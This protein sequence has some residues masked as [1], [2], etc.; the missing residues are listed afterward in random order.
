M[1]FHSVFGAALSVAAMIL[2]ASS[3]SPS[4]PP[5]EPEV[6]VSASFPETNVFGH[7]INGEKNSLVLSVESKSDRNVTL[8]RVA[9]SVHHAETNTLI[10]NLTSMPYNVPLLEGV[11]LQLPYAF[12]SEFKPGDLRLNIWVEHA[13]EDS[14]YRISAYDSIVTVVEPDVSI[15]DFK[16]LSTYFMVTAIFG[17]LTYFAY[18]AFI[19]Q[20][21]KSRSK[22]TAPTPVSAPVGTVTATGAGG[23][24]EEW[25]PEHHLKKS[26]SGKKSGGITSGTSGDELSGGE[27][28]QTEGRKRKGKK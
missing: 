23:Y 22:R 27:V 15:L 24:Q 10:K 26:K 14:T 2:S 28:S 1:R 6:I 19:P 20:A 5:P 9:G 21:K 17:G 11:K 3:T 25:I 13:V 8:V 7:V 16:L 4:S 18:L 12:Y